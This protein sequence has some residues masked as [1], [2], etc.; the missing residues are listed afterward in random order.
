MMSSIEQDM[1]G[2]NASSHVIRGYQSVFPLSSLEIDIVL[3]AAK[4]RISHSLVM[5]VYNYKYVTPGNEYLIYWN[6][7]GWKA[8]DEILQIPRQ[9]IV[10]AWLSS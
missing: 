7:G 2:I 4:V 9:D 10:T 8:L 6:E 5:G 3:E 1:S